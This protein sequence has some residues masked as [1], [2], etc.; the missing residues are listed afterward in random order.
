M[1]IQL[2]KIDEERFFVEFTREKDGIKRGVKVSKEEFTR[3]LNDSNK[4]CNILTMDQFQQ[5]S[6]SFCLDNS[7]SYT[8]LGDGIVEELGE[9]KGKIAKM[10]RKGILP[11]NFS[12][13]DIL[14]LDEETRKGLM[15]ELGDLSW[16]VAVLA[17]WCGWDFSFVGNENTNKLAD[18]KKRNVIASE[19]DYR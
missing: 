15:F 7:Y 3:F 16:F 4:T 6:K 8:Y 9:F 13:E 5:N 11:V 19:G 2:R 18:R 12:R 14:N 17:E 10:V 1:K